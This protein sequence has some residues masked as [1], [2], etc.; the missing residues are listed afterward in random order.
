VFVV[1]GGSPGR[2]EPFRAS[3]PLPRRSPARAGTAH[4]SSASGTIRIDRLHGRGGEGPRE[5]ALA[6]KA[7]YVDGLMASI[8]RF[9]RTG[10]LRSYVRPFDAAHMA[11][12]PDEVRQSGALSALR[13]LGSCGLPESSRSRSRPSRSSRFL[14]LPNFQLGSLR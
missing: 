12:G 1:E 9:E 6:A 8:F 3:Q 11:A 14:C 13:A 10:R 2:A 4:A 7:A 5:E